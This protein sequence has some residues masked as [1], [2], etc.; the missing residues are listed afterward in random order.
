[1]TFISA[2]PQWKKGL[3]KKDHFSEKHSGWDRSE[4]I[5]CLHGRQ[6]AAEVGHSCVGKD[7][8]AVPFVL[9]NSTSL[10]NFAL[11]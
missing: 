3:Q 4:A 1:M 7:S 9:S 8:R 11:R 6:K 5:P 10:E 2:P